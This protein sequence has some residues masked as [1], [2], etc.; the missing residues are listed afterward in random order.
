VLLPERTKDEELQVAVFISAEEEKRAFPGLE[1]A[2]FLSVVPPPP[3]P[4]PQR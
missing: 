3:P 2:L 4:P 1:D